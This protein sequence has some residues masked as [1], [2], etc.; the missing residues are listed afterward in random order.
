MIVSSYPSDFYDFLARTE[1]RHYWF[2]NRNR[3]I[4]S[5]MREVVGQLK[6]KSV[7]D[8]GCGT[9]FVLAALGQ[10]G[11]VPYGVDMHAEGLAYARDRI[12]GC[13]LARDVGEL[14]GAPPFDVVMLCDVI[15]HV[16]RES[17]ILQ[18]ARDALK[19]NGHVVVT[20]PAHG[21]MWSA[22][23]QA[24]GHWRRYTKAALI[25]ALQRASFGVVTARY[26]NFL[27]L[28]FQVAAQ[29]A[30]KCWPYGAEQPLLLERRL[31]VPPEPL[32]RLLKACFP[33][34]LILS[35]LP[36]SA[37]SSLIAVGQPV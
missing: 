18:R 19:V 8:M 15:E 9:G 13:V 7:L 30:E 16:Q 10:A 12:P 20:V 25:T 34:E 28:P 4:L 23:D 32:N 24:S 6:G 11:M 29:W 3:L 2:V 14:A 5:T 33:L 31:A 37:G 21:W 22:A 1:E 17:D 26:F 35:R 27:T 36:I